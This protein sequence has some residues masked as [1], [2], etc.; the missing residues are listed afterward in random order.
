MQTDWSRRLGEHQG[1]VSDNHCNNAY[2]ALD[3]I[4]TCDNE[5]KFDIFSYSLSVF[6][7]LKES[8]GP[9]FFRKKYFK[10]IQK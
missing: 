6:N 2:L 7:K 9:Q 5:N 8:T 10:K 3:Y 1:D 4:R